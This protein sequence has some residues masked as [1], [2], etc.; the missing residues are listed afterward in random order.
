MKYKIVV[1]SC[2]DLTDEMKGWDNL[3]VVPMTLQIADYVIADDTNFNQDDF[4]KR[5]LESDVLAQSACPSPQAFADACDGDFD[6][7]FIIT[8][9]SRLSGSYNSAVQGVQMYKEEHSDNKSIH[10][11]NS[12]ATAGK[13]ALIAMEI[14]KLADN[15]RNFDEIVEYINDFIN[16][17][18]QLYFCLE[19]F[20][21]LK[22]N[23]RL[24]NLA[25]N[26]IEAL[27]VKIIGRAVD[28][29][30]SIAGKDLTQKRALI[31]LSQFIAKDT[32]GADL[33]DKLCIISHVCCKEKAQTI[34]QLIVSNTDFNDNNVI[35]IKASGLNSL[36]A[37]NGG[38]IIAFNY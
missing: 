10:V 35:I 1:D 3:T 7:V 37:A 30:V 12:L 19:T 17:R 22:G 9:T 4:I 8:I 13:E 14:K 27:K 18:S 11:F 6:S 28:G 26:V 34:K 31:K 29:K 5:M 25:A 23:G 2:C 21:I 36:Y 33:S 38:T 20:D 32:A 15:G 24:F 16:N